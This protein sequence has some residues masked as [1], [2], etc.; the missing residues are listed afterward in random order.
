L[1]KLT[2]SNKIDWLNFLFQKS[3][4]NDHLMESLW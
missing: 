3:K 2:Y 1:T 4:D